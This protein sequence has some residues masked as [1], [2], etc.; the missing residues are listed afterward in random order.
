MG[1]ESRRGC[2]K[3][4][5]RYFDGLASSFM[6]IT[7][8][9]VEACGK[10]TQASLLHKYFQDIKKKSFLTR[11]PGGFYFADSIRD[12]LLHNRQIDL[13]DKSAFLLFSAVRSE[14]CAKYILPKLK[15]GYQVVCDRFSDSSLVYQGFA[16]EVAIKDI[17][18]INRF[19]TGGLTPDI[20]FYLRVS[21][22]ES[23]KRLIG[24]D[25][26]KFEQVGLE[27]HRRLIDGFDKLAEL[28]PKRV[29]VIDGHLSIEDIHQEVLTA[30][31]NK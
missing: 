15:E 3:Q 4:R 8:E 31:R 1:G 2:Q 27:C 29:V 11:E 16:G 21:L 23:Q 7:F 13:S 5:K 9:G 10:S 26:D 22:Q 6:F 19:S 17:D 18:W 28:N 30:L 20:T 25:K 14:H 24:K 12:I